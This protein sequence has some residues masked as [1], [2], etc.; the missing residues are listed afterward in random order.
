MWAGPGNSNTQQVYMVG[1]GNVSTDKA[2]SPGSN[3]FEAWNTIEIELDE[4]ND[5]QKVWVNGS[6]EI[7]ETGWFAN[8]V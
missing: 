1:E 7:S 2:E 8:M 3:P 4:P 6:L 5:T